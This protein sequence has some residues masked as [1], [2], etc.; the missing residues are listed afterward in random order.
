M[1]TYKRGDSFPDI[2]EGGKKTV[3]LYFRDQMAAAENITAADWSSVP[4]DLVFT[5]PSE[6]GR[7]AGTTIS[8][9][10]AGQAYKVTCTVDTD[11]GQKIHA[12]KSISFIAKAA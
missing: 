5:A 10:A 4:P 3:S 9:G 7:I 11:T 6:S 8:G 2:Y 12:E 1:T